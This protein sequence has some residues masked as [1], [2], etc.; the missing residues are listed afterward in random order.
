MFPRPRP[1]KSPRARPIA[2][3]FNFQNLLS[4][5]SDREH[6]PATD[7]EQPRKPKK[8]S[9]CLKP[10]FVCLSSLCGST[11][12]LKRIR[13]PKDLR[14][15]STPGERPQISKPYTSTSRALPNLTP[16]SN[17]TAHAP[18]V[19]PQG[20]RRLSEMDPMLPPPTV[21]SLSCEPGVDFTQSNKPGQSFSRLFSY[22][23]TEDGIK[24]KPPP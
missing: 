18:P 7:G 2:S 19:P 24:W 11:V 14:R 12:G 16:R 21:G 3:H 20:L 23:T 15:P 22:P 8:E 5:R 1:P 10:L 9:P 13:S 17:R 6:S 4:K